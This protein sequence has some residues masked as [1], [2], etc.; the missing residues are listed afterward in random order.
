MNI[1]RDY[2]SPETV[3]VFFT[4]HSQQAFRARIRLFRF[5]RGQL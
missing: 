4:R 3:C 5:A 1:N 2:V